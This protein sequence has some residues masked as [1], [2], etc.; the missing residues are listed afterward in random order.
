MK[1]FAI[2]MLLSLTALNVNAQNITLRVLGKAN[3]V[4]YAETNGIKISFNKNQLENI[5]KLI[6]TISLIGIKNQL[7][8][9]IESN[10]SNKK[11]FKIEESNLDLF[12]KLL[13]VCNN[14]KVKI[15][16]I[17]YKLP[18]HKFENEDNNAILALNNATSQAKI[19]A[20][21]LKYKIVKILNIDD[22]TT[23]A[24]PFYDKFDM[25]SESGKIL[26]KLLTLLGGGNSLHKTESSKPI[27]EGGYNIWVTY[28]LK[29][30]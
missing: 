12:D 15:D 19:I 10:I 7:V 30:K 29:K 2:L 20:N 8:P 26:V 4:E 28:E 25:E 9:I 22:E 13:M 24:D 14:L 1:V 23:Y 5:T 6:D 17:Y 18:E 11:K 16:K 27:R 3:Y 21:N